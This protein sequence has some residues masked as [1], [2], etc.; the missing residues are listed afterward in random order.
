[1]DTNTRTQLELNMPEDGNADH[2][3]PPIQHITR[4]LWFVDDAGSRVIF[5]RHEPIF[6]F[7]LDDQL[8]LRYVAVQLRVMGLAEQQEIAAAFGH[9][10]RSQREWEALYQQAGLR[11]LERKPGSGR[12]APLDTSQEAFLRTWFEQGLSYPVMA[13]RLGVGLDVVKR[14]LRRLGL[15]RRSNSVQATLP[16]T[17]DT[18]SGSLAAEPS[19]AAADAPVEAATRESADDVTEPKTVSRAIMTPEG[20]PADA[21]SASRLESTAHVSPL[22]P[23]SP[24][25]AEPPSPMPVVTVGGGSV[26]ICKVEVVRIPVSEIDT[27]RWTPPAAEHARPATATSTTATSTTA[28]S[29]TAKSTTATSAPR[30]AREPSVTA[31]P[32]VSRPATNTSALD[33]APRGFTLDVDPKDRSGD[34]ALA[35]L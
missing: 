32:D 24:Q 33:A 25:S 10:V 23:V 11:G 26:V 29:T 3:F 4:Q 9:S 20:V 6:Q 16:G 35:R 31:S 18:D 27:Y 13:Q 19:T 12:P 22:L 21:D 17:D 1:M 8:T 2:S 5:C 34:R 15:R 7:A 14:V 30:E 28:K